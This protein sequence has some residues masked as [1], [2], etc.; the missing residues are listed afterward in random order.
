MKWTMKFVREIKNYN[1]KETENNINNIF[2]L[3]VIFY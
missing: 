2:Y 1:A 3:D